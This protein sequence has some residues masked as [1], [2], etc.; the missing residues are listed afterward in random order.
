MKLAS[1]YLHELSRRFFF[2]YLGLR[3]TSA[4]ILPSRDTN[5]HLLNDAR[6]MTNPE[7]R[8]KDRLI[9]CSLFPQLLTTERK[10]MLGNRETGSDDHSEGVISRE[11]R[12]L[13]NYPSPDVQPTGRTL[14]ER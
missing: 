5:G 13:I 8:T 7:T 12:C 1:S 9:P 2:N 6:K 4:R 3:A 11:S 10:S 14:T